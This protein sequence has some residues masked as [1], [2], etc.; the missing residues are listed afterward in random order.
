MCPSAEASEREGACAGAAGKGTGRDSLVCGRS[1]PW[2]SDQS[3][4]WHQ[5]GHKW[6]GWEVVEDNHR[7]RA[8]AASVHN[9]HTQWEWHCWGLGNTAAS[10]VSPASF[11][12]PL[13]YRSLWALT[14]ADVMYLSFSLTVRTKKMLLWLKVLVLLLVVAKNFPE[15]YC[16]STFKSICLP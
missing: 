8:W 13:W 15:P 1:W 7:A 2:S 6:S 10:C 11:V 9:T 14:W 4:T 12:F 3:W 5:K 16:F